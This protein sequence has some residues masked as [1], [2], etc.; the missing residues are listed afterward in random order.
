VENG[1]DQ[2]RFAVKSASAR[3]KGKDFRGDDQD[4]G[5]FFAAFN[6]GISKQSSILHISRR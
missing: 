4:H 1:Q 5:C 2:S 3:P 6:S